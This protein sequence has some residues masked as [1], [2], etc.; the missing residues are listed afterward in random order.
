MDV[1][2]ENL[3]YNLLL[4]LKK[5]KITKRERAELIVKYLTSTGLSQRALAVE[6]DIPHSTIQDWLMINRISEEQYRDYLDKGLTETDIYRLLR[7]N[8][9]KKGKELDKEIIISQ[10][11][12]T[13]KKFSKLI[14]CAKELDKRSIGEIK[15]L[16]NVL[17][18]ILLHYERRRL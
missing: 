5:K 7:E 16:I 15:D 17:N 4:D 18:R 12:R 14:K 2:S 8:K 13:K 9:L 10:V 1:V 11:K 6:L 3:I